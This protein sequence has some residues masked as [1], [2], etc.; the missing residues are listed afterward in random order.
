MPAMKT[1]I[2]TDTIRSLSK[3]VALDFE[4]VLGDHVIDVWFPR[5]LDREWGGFLCDFDYR[6][7]SCGPNEKLL[8]FHARHTWFAAEASRIYPNDERLRQAIEQG[9]SY[10]CGPLWDE[11]AGGWFSLLD[12]AGKPIEQHTKHTHGFAYAILACVAVY[13]ATAKEAAL[14][15]AREGFDWIYRHAR[16][17]RYGGYFGALHRDG[18][19]IRDD[20]FDGRI[21]WKGSIDTPLG[22]KDIS[23]HSGLLE[24]FTHLYR[25]WPD[26]RV[27]SQLAEIVDI[28]C[29]RMTLPAGAHH[30][31]C[32]VSGLDASAAPNA[33]WSPILQRISA[34]RCRRFNGSQG[35]NFLCGE[36]AHRPRPSLRLG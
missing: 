35:R 24:T 14:D 6:W 36:R 28:L 22:C 23:V 9:F 10:L 1:V 18:T 29:N 25:A 32:L 15:L 13:R 33:I 31:Y 26:A 5:S 27:G 7:K 17:S 21:H 3:P 19:I 8:E 4:A 12:R 20:N 2:S 34:S 16:D 11:V 30:Q